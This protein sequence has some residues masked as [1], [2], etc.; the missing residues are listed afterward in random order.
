MRFP[1]TILPLLLLLSV[2]A[3]H[4]QFGGELSNPFNGGD[5]DLEIGGDIFSDFNEDL[6]TN[7]VLEDERFYRYGRFFSFSLG[8]GTTTFTGN[9]G[10]AYDDDN[11]SYNFGVSYFLNFFTNAL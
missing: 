7:K 11:P 1:K 2:S 10:L 6:D 5:D 4:A 9:R 8:L 3:S